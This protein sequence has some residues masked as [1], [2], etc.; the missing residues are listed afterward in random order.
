MNTKTRIFRLNQSAIVRM[1]FLTHG[2]VER[3]LKEKNPAAVALGKI[4]S[5]AK[6]KASRQNGK[7]GGRPVTKNR[8]K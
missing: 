8:P 4:K 2:T 5:S 6:A 1:K 7:L 3:F